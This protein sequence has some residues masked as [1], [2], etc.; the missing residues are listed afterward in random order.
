LIRVINIFNAQKADR[1]QI[2]LLFVIVGWS[3][4]SMGSM[5][6]QLFYYLTFGGFGV[7]TIYRLFTLDKEIKKYNIKL[8]RNCGMST[9]DII[10]IGLI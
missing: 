6:K 2:W 10:K 4:G 3:Y 8:A 9:Q 1:T 7:W 5:S